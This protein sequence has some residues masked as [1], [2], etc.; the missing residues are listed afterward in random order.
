MMSEGKP[1]DGYVPRHPWGIE[2]D[3]DAV[4][5]ARGRAWS[6][7]PSKSGVHSFRLVPRSTGKAGGGRAELHVRIR[8]RDGSVTDAY[9]YF[10]DSESEARAIY[11]RLASSPHPFT[12]V[13][14]PDVIQAKV[15]Y[16]RA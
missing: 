2:N 4:G 8:R 16:T 13:L 3:G 7:G 9:V 1:M 11:S 5:P 12:E 15:P 10:F 6:L 14:V